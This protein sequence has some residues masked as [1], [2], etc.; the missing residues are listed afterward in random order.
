MGICMYKLNIYTV[1]HDMCIDLCFPFYTHTHT[2]TVHMLKP[3][4]FVLDNPKTKIIKWNPII[5]KAKLSCFYFPVE[6][7]MS[8]PEKG[9]GILGNE[10]TSPSPRVLNYGK[11]E[12]KLEVHF[13]FY[14]SKLSE[15]YLIKSLKI[16]LCLTYSSGI[17]KRI[18]RGKQIMVFVCNP[19]H[20]L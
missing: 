15:L 1:H 18:I 8:F 10:I 13:Q 12:Y 14:K 19:R 2:H 7:L 6:V 5:H 11:F 9:S 16:K 17:S 3:M 20:E 4:S